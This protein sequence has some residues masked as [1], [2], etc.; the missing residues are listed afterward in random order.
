MFW[1]RLPLIGGPLRATREEAT[2][3]GIAAITR[4]AELVVEQI[5][6]TAL[7]REQLDIDAIVTD[8]DI[9]AIIARIDLIGLAD[10]IIDGVDLPAIIRESTEGV[11]AE[12]MTDVRTQTARADDMVSGFVDRMLGREPGTRESP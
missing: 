10:Q 6:L 1:E 8:V 11:T 2:R 5:D 4:V 7:I 9:E 12:V 3:I